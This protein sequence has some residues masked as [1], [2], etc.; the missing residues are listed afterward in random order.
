MAF[1]RVGWSTREQ[2]GAIIASNVLFFLK[3]VVR[4]AQI[5]KWFARLVQMRARLCYNAYRSVNERKFW[6]GS[7]PHAPI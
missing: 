4:F 3:K 2:E 5:R 6:E 1:E 7:N